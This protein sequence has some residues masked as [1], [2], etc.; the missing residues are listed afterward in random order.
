MPPLPSTTVKSAP[1]ERTAFLSS[2]AG[3]P[4]ESSRPDEQYFYGGQEQPQSAPAP[5]EFDDKYNYDFDPSGSY[6]TENYS[7][8]ESSTELALHHAP[9]D[10]ALGPLQNADQ[11]AAYA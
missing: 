8:L 4:A 5:V 9:Y 10:A 11:Y 6:L 1:L 3:S 2:S 7:L